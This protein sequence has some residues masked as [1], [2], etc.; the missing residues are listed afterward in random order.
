MNPH[1]AELQEIVWDYYA[2]NGRVFAWRTPESDGSYDPYKILVSE[3]MLQQTQAQRVVPKYERFLE[4]FPTVH[5]LARAPLAAVLSEWSGLGY[6]R[7]AKF[8]WQ[9]A[10]TIVNHHHGVFPITQEALTMLPGVGKNTAAAICVYAFNQPLVF[11]ETNIR[12]VFI[13]HFFPSQTDVSDAQLMP[14]VAAACDREH[15]REWYWA[16]MDY[17]V[18][19]KATIGNASRQ[20]RHYAKQSTFVG[21]KRQVRGRIIALLVARPYELPELV[22][23]LGDERAENIIEELLHEGLITKT[24]NSLH[25]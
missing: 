13:H 9:C 1:I 16:L 21:S 24:N 15:P 12:T 8:L 20:S 14:L 25:L 3:L 4:V 7:R 22:T 5:S 19:L 2:K 6:N 10:D 17:G 18:H 23:T 11:I